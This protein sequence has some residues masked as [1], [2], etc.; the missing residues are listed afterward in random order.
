MGLSAYTPGQLQA[1]L[2]LCA[3]SKRAIKALKWPYESD[4]DFKA[5]IPPMLLGEQVGESP[6]PAISVPLRNTASL[7]K[8]LMVC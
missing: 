3:C 7:E 1:V 5:N 6:T 2:S 8:G 4:T